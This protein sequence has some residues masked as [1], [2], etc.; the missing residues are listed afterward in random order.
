MVERVND[1]IK[2]RCRSSRFMLHIQPCRWDGCYPTEVTT[3]TFC[4][5]RKYNEASKRLQL[6]FAI[7]ILFSRRVIVQLYSHSVVWYMPLFAIHI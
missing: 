5:P 2:S 3:S 7:F 1:E 6:F 4:L